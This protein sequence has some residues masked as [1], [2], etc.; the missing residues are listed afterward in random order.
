MDET[1]EAVNHYAVSWEPS[2]VPGISYGTLT[3]PGLEF[4]RVEY[5]ADVTIHSRPLGACYGDPPPWE[6]VATIRGL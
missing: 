5:G 2:D 4:M 1:Q 6:L 3:E